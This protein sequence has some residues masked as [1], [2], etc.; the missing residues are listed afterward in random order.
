MR[1]VRFVCEVSVMRGILSCCVI[2]VMVA[3]SV[4]SAQTPTPTPTPVQTPVPAAPPPAQETPTPAA[5]AARTN[6][7][8]PD[9]SVLANFVGAVGKNGGPERSLQLTEVEVALSSVVDPYGRADFFLAATP[10]G[11]E[12]EEGYITF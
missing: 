8:N 1:P 11:V 2:A 12:V 5:P 7:F 10:E 3:P 9:I 4:A 6:V